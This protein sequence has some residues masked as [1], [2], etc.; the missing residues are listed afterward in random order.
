MTNNEDCT[1]DQLASD[2][3]MLLQNRDGIDAHRSFNL[4]VNCVADWLDEQF[5]DSGKSATW[6]GL[7]ASTL[8]SGRHFY[9]NPPAWQTFHDAVRQRLSW[10]GQLR[11]ARGLS[12]DSNSPK[13]ETLDVFVVHGHDNEFKLDVARTLSQL[14]LSP[15]ILHERPNRGQTIIEKFERESNVGFAVILLSP[16]DVAYA[17]NAKDQIK[18]RARQN[19]VLELGYFVG[20]LGRSRVC[21]LKKGDLEVPSDFA[22]VVYTSFDENG[23]WRLALA[24]EL[25]AAGYPIDLNDLANP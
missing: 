8:V 23:G 17:L 2:G 16:D 18:N 24:Q 20:K 13:C 7:A 3:R 14:G 25:M 6:S 22:G 10:L 21:A 4:W 1:I 19:V 15:I 12:G 5:P 11:P 9:D